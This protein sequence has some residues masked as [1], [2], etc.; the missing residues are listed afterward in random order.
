MK[1]IV[2][3]L[4]SVFGLSL[5]AQSSTVICGTYRVIDSRGGQT[6]FVISSQVD[7]TLYIMNRNS[8]IQELDRYET[9]DR[10]CVRANNIQDF[11]GYS[12]IENDPEN[13]NRRQLTQNNQ[14]YVGLDYRPVHKQIDVVDIWPGNE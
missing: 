10:M 11:D 9:G 12:L 7:K 13:P 5:Y 1:Y 3:A 14:V 2:F 4:A 8:D 6:H